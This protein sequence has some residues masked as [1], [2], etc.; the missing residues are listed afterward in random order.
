[1]DDFLI[2]T[3]LREALQTAR[4]QFDE[5]PASEC[6]RLVDNILNDD[7][8]TGCT[9]DGCSIVEIC[10]TDSVIDPFLD[11]VNNEPF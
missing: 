3:T 2:M 11:E 7:S 6:R 5:L 1:M 9:G 10:R 8:L 4:N